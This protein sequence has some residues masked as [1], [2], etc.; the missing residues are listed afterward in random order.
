VNPGHPQQVCRCSI[1]SRATNDSYENIQLA[2]KF[3]F[4]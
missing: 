2:R 4:F 3:I 1:P